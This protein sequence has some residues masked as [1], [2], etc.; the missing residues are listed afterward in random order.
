MLGTQLKK[1]HFGLSLGGVFIVSLTF[2]WFN[3]LRKRSRKRDQSRSKS[4]NFSL[5]VIK[6]V[7]VV[8]LKG[9]CVYLLSF[10]LNKMS[11][12]TRKRDFN[13]LQP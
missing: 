6:V 8:K 4:V 11:T 7:K 3:R 9:Y 2:V 12:I 5:R 13:T 1:L 10:D